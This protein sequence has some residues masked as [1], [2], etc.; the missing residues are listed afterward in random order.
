MD[1]RSW[2]FVLLL[3]AVAVFRALVA[4]PEM[5]VVG[6]VSLP[7]AGVRAEL[8]QEEE[9]GCGCCPTLW[10]GGIVAT[11]ADL[12]AVRAGDLADVVT[13][14]G[15]R[16]ALECAEIVPCIRLGRW[17]ISWRGIVRSGGD[18][19]I[20]SGGRALRFVML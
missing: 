7:A 12:S 19:L 5:S 20:V 16:Y 17:L 4:V 18:V 9:A 15:G 10:N 6:R 14:D 8:L 11:D 3:A 1:G 13:L 2:C